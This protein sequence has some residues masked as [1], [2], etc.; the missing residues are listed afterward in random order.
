MFEIG[1][2]ELLLI[3]IVALVV[4]GPKELPGVLR[5]LGQW[6]AKLR[7]MASEFQNQ[8]HEAMREAELADLK[9]QVDELK[10]HA[11]SYANL[12]PVADVRREFESTQRAIETSMAEQPKSESKPPSELPPDREN[13]S[14]TP[15]AAPEIE[16]AA[17]PTPDAGIPLTT[18]AAAAPPGSEGGETPVHDAGE[19]PA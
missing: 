1:W 7:R 17:A 18:P 8:F 2:S 10:T 9:K 13:A 6:T 14:L 11:K 3:A 19:K 5:T 15:R 16:A 12:D 4:I